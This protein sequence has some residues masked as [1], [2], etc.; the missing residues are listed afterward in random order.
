[1]VTFSILPS[2]AKGARSKYAGDTGEYESRP[3]S[4]ESLPVML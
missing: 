1:M 2:K 3:T 4:K